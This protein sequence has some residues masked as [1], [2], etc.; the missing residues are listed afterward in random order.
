MNRFTNV[1]INSNI[2]MMIGRCVRSLPTSTSVPTPSQTSIEISGS[3]GIGAVSCGRTNTIDIFDLEE[4][5]DDES[6]D[7]SSSDEN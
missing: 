1:S 7:E 3:R 6:D 4:D 5:E 2:F